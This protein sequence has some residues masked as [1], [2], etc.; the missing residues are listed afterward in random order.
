M[1]RFPQP[2]LALI[3][4]IDWARLAAYIDGEGH[5]CIADQVHKTATRGQR[6]YGYA[7]VMIAN[8]DPRLPQWLVQQF[9]GSVQVRATHSTR[10][11]HQ[12]RWKPCYQWSLSNGR[13]AELLR[14]ALP[15][16]LLKREQAEL[17]I[18]FQMT[19]RRW[20]VKGT[21]DHVL[22]QR[23]ELRTKLRALTTRGPVAASA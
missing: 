1:K 20:G 12:Q 7:K 14:Y 6:R 10:S 11:G 22:A 2:D 3:T 21:P 16:F 18:A 23:Q 5:V 13:A 9:G 15:Y 8:T 4:Q 19:S 17:A